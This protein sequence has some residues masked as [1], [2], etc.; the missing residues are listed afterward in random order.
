MGYTIE[1]TTSK[2]G[3]KLYVITLSPVEMVILISLFFIYSTILHLS[4]YLP[5]IS[6]S[7]T[8]INKDGQLPNE[9]NDDEGFDE[10]VIDKGDGDDQLY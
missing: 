5:W 10:G 3:Y 1:E 6:L 7:K 2:E 9:D 4:H 8:W